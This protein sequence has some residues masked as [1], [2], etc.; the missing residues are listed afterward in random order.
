MKRTSAPSRALAQLA[1]LRAVARHDERQAG[2]ARGVDRVGEALL[3]RQPAG[4]ERE[5]PSA[6][7]ERDRDVALHGAD[8]LRAVAERRAQLAEPGE[9]ELARDDERV[10]AARRAGAATARAGAVGDR[11][12]PRAA[13]AVQPH[14]RERVAAVAARAVRPAGEAQALRA[15]EAVVVQVQHDARARLARGGERP[16]AERGVDVVGVHH[17][18]AG[19]LDGVRDVLGLE[20][21]AQE[22]E[23]R[24]GGCRA[25]PSRARA[26]PLPRRGARGSA[27][28]G[29]RRPAPPRRGGGSGCAG[30]GSRRARA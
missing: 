18:G 21:A 23:P 29:P 14:P 22:P 28:A 11:L 1:G 24:R 17:A 9:R 15:H 16:P 5:P 3:G 30:A 13:A 10:D 6:A 7:V 19:A 25:R 4:G 12:G 2:R 8:H 20:A 27:T 26:P